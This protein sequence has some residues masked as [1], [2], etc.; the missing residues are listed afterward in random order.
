M[1]K[2]IKKLWAISI[3]ALVLV[4]GM[5][6]L[7]LADK[8]PGYMICA[9]IGLLLALYGEQY[10]L[11]KKFPQGSPLFAP[12]AFLLVLSWLILWRLNVEFALKQLVWIV[13]GL[14][15]LSLAAQVVGRMPKETVLKGQYIWLAVTLGLLVL[16]LLIGIE[17]GGARSWFYIGPVSVQPSELAKITFLLFMVSW[18]KNARVPNGRNVLILLSGVLAVLLVLVKQVDLGG[19]LIFYSIFI[20]IMYLSTGKRSWAIIGLV[21]LVVAGLAA[22]Y[23]FGHVRVRVQTWWDPWSDPQHGGYQLIQALGAFAAGG[24]WG[25]GLGGGQPYTIPAAHTDFI[26]AV[27][28]EQMGFVGC[29]VCLSMYVCF[30][31][32]ACKRAVCIPTRGSFLLASGIAFF[33][34]AQSFIIIG[35]VTKFIPLTGVT[36]PFLSYGGSSLVTSLGAL[37]ILIGLCRQQGAAVAIQKRKIKRIWLAVLLVAGMLLINLLYWQ[38]IK[39]PEILERMLT[40]V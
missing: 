15:A 37:G 18:Y 36:L 19:A 4:W 24:W 16:P 11:N 10:Y 39:G 8:A 33:F 3:C 28:G 7:Y 9:S 30:L 34:I 40:M 38:I 12:V 21:M 20:I 13:S 35:G 17:R 26:F 5:A 23:S 25:T 6:K 32:L 29:A 31:Y 1:G 2:A 27:L 14:V 22:Y